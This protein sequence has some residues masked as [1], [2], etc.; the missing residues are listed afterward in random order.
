MCYT[1]VEWY[2]PLNFVATILWGGT[3]FGRVW[4]MDAPCS[5]KYNST[6]TVHPLWMTKHRS[7][8]GR[9]VGRPRGL[10]RLRKPESCVPTLGCPISLTCSD[11]Y[12]T[13]GVKFCYSKSAETCWQTC[14]N[15]EVAIRAW[16]TLVAGLLAW[17]V[18]T[19]VLVAWIVTTGFLSIW[20]RVQLKC[21][22][23]RWRTGGE[24]KW[25]TGEWNG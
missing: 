11:V 4:H 23:T 1:V 17:C 6:R 13:F 8:G 12:P 3:Y 25:E 15:G 24:S 16:Q 22:G 5:A 14:R 9:L 18:H 20:S 2:L 10:G 7:A 19:A 21:D